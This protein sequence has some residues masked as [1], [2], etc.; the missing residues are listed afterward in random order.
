MQSEKTKVD[1]DSRSYEFAL[2]VI[3]LV[4]KL[5]REVSAVEI[6]R[7]IV[8]SGTSIA[9][10]I[11]EAQGAC[12]KSDFTHKMNIALKEARETHLWLRL[13]SDSGFGLQDSVTDLV[14]ESM[15]IRNILG[16]IVKS[17]RNKTIQ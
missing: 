14:K 13:I 8:R 11:E 6:G 5:P 7:Q 17:S 2:R 4:R 1:I 15:E 12:S 16:A 3:S 10:N 9:A